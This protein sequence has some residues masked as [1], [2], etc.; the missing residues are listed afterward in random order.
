MKTPKSRLLCSTLIA[1][2]IIA[3]GAPSVAQTI[4]VEEIVVTARKRAENLQ[5]VPITVSAFTAET[6][7]QA[8]VRDVR[9]ISDLT[10]NFDLE[11]VGGRRGVQGG[12]SRPVIRGQSNILGE[13]NA[14]TFVDGFLFTDSLLSFPFDIVERV[15]VVKG[16]QSALFGRST[17]A[18]AVNL[19]TRR[20]SNEFVNKV[21]G[22][23]AEHNDYEVNLL[24]SGP[25]IEDKVFYMVHGRYYDFGGEYK[26][27]VDGRTVADEESWNINASLEFR[28]NEDATIL[29]R[30]GYGEDDDGHQALFLLDRFANNCFLDTARQYYCGVV[31]PADEVNLNLDALNGLD[32]IERDVLRLTGTLEWALGDHQLTIQGG[33]FRT[34]EAIGYDGDYLAVPALGGIFHRYETTDRNEWSAEA[35]IDSPQDQDLRY[36]FG[37]Y[38]YKRDLDQVRLS[39]STLNQTADLGFQTVDNWAIF[40]ALE[41]DITQDITARSE[42]R[43][44]QDEIGLI[45]GSGADGFDRNGP[46]ATNNSVKFKS[47]LPRFTLDY[48][49]G[50]ETLFYFI[51]ARGNKPGALNN[52]PDLTPEQQF[53]DEEFAWT[54]E[55]GSKNTLMDGRL[56]A[57]FAAFY[58]DW[59]NQQ[60]TESV[61]DS[62]GVPASILTN[63]GETSVYGF[64]MELAAQITEN[65][66][67][68]MTYGLSDATF[69][70][71]IDTTNQ[72]ALFGNPSAAGAQTP[73]SSRNQYHWYS[74]YQRPILEGIDIFLRGDYKLQSSKFAQIHNLAETGDRDVF[75]VKLGL[76]ADNWNITLFVDNV[77]DNR[78]PSTVI[79]FADL[80][81]LNLPGR[82]PDN[83]AQDNVAGTTAI[84]RGF[85]Y[86]LAPSRQIGVTASYSF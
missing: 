56:V 83:P 57:N 2:G 18:G 16:P 55:L 13:S 3:A 84:E 20:G 59:Q 30:G 25:I 32:G 8:G 14:A 31:P 29:L 41:Y 75:D 38:I 12:L 10:P 77:F 1:G 58:I 37:G 85:L 86:P 82:N 70:V 40:G 33:V 65:W 43:Y 21:S 27:S 71:F 34:D 66:S 11:S 62:N 81:N 28:L 26:N 46:N 69:D 52:Q 73:N 50:D 9:D 74:T 45:S 54:Y 67:A 80:G 6:I 61:F 7:R 53:A 68:G 48:Q 64:E 51:A 42:L 63:A 17:F 22:S 35:R 44:Q 24:S 23:I 4:A 36:S 5:E 47:I 15:E 79:R 76:E 19:V 49:W 39:P 78:T 60:L 72:Q